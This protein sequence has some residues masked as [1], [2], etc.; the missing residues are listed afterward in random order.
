MSDPRDWSQGGDPDEPELPPELNPRGPR[1]SAGL[2]PRPVPSRGQGRPPRSIPSL[3]GPE[4]PPQKA[5]PVRPTR[6]ALGP[7]P[8][9][10]DDYA[11]EREAGVEVLPTR[12]ERHNGR[13]VARRVVAGAAMTMSIVMLLVTGLG[14]FIVSGLDGNINRIGLVSTR[15]D[16]Q[17]PDKVKKDARNVLLVGSDSRDNGSGIDRGKGKTFTT[18]QRADTIIIAH[19]YADSD[20]A[21]LVSFPRDSYV[22]IPAFTNPKTKKTRAAHKD[23]IN[24][25]ISE[26]GLP[27]LVAT[28]EDLTGL[29]IDNFLVIDFAGFKAMVNQLGGVEVCL[30]K[31]AKE[32]ESEID[33]PAGRQVI[34]GDQ[35]LAFVRQRHGLP[36][37]DIDRIARQQVFIG[38][39]IRKVLT[40]GTLLNIS[41][42]KGFLD[43][44]TKNVSTDDGLSFDELV[45]IGLRLRSFS[46]GGVAFTTVPFS[47]PAARRNGASVVLLDDAKVSA[48]FNQLR[49]D[50]VPAALAPKPAPGK[51]VAPVTGLFVKPSAIRVAVF[52]GGGTK[53]LG[54]RAATDLAKA[55]FV[56]TGTP[57]NRGSGASATV[58]HY[59]PDKVDSARTLAASIPGATLQLDSTLT[60]TLEVVVGLD[61]SG[62]QA[63]TIGKPP[64]SS[65]TS[66]PDTGDNAPV[67]TAANEGCIN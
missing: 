4:K 60:R 17:R 57:G 41:K 50:K 38:S 18:G 44:L 15:P 23:K 2:P 19:L 56:I 12:S 64:A 13:R 59:G 37:G 42:L 63:V 53:G 48:L 29:R 7:V 45:K 3:S 62:T 22:T 6:T 10:S 67:Q 40:K 54:A 11:A 31:P 39:L 27:L 43:T 46:S 65:P 14:Y 5:L 61:Y 51:G 35:A 9:Q 32:K 28:L 20:A 8:F 49:L 47:D 26:G 33:L 1:P 66:A 55:G 24:S 34:T 58:V 25:A 36:R 21:Q 16:G 30:L 52:N